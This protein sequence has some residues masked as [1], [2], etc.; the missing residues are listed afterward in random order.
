[1]KMGFVGELLFKK[2]P[3]TPSRILNVF[4]LGEPFLRKGFPKPF[5]KTFNAFWVGSSGDVSA[6]V[7]NVQIKSQRTKA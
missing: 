7:G 2:F 4:F 5:P 1:M 6:L 3:H